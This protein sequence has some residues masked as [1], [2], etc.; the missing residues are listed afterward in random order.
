L[1]QRQEIQALLRTV[2]V[3]RNPLAAAEQRNTP[4]VPVIRILCLL[5]PAL[6]M[7][8]K[9]CIASGSPPD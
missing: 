6:A 3:F 7:I 4:P 5:F 8:L 2:I 1:R 9:F